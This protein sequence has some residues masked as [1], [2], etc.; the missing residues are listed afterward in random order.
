M[1]SPE[2]VIDVIRHHQ[3]CIG[4]GCSSECRTLRAAYIHIVLFQHRCNV[5]NSFYKIIAKHSKRCRQVSCGIEFCHFVK[6]EL[7]LNG[8]SVLPM[9]LLKARAA[10][11]EEFRKCEQ[12]GVHQRDFHCRHFPSPKLPIVNGN[13][14][15]RCLHH[16]ILSAFPDTPI[17]NTVGRLVAKT[18]LLLNNLFKP[19]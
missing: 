18:A 14:R 15:L 1:R 8:V 17:G 10:V 6:H 19:S 7:H 9:Q 4:L 16:K 5:W 13:Q 11:E 2:G 12:L 3:S